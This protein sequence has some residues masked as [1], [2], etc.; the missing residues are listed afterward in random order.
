MLDGLYNILDDIVLENKKRTSIY[1][2]IGSSA[3]TAFYDINMGLWTIDQKNN[4]QYPQFLKTLKE[5]LPFDPLHI[6]LIDPN[7]ENP[8]FITWDMTKN[9]NKHSDEWILDDKYNKYE[10]N[11]YKNIISTI[12]VYTLKS[13]V[14]CY[15]YIDNYLGTN[16]D[17]FFVKLNNYSIEHNWFT[18]VHNFSGINMQI[19]AILYDKQ[20]KHHINHIIYGTAS[21][22]DDGCNFDLTNLNSQYVYEIYENKIHVF[23]PFLN[24]NKKNNEILKISELSQYDEK[25]KINTNIIKE[26]IKE[27]NNFKKNLILNEI[28]TFIRQFGMLLVD[29][30]KVNLNSVYINNLLLSNL[31]YEF[32]LQNL[33]QNKEYDKILNIF[34]KLLHDELV[35]YFCISFGENTEIIITNKI[36]IMLAEK[37]PYRWYDFI[38]QLFL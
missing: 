32:N 22:T 36:N 7:L 8:P 25:S 19:L 17:D 38:K 26:Q 2:S 11:Y 35:S 4:Q 33:Y 27:Y 37:N 1:I 14:K 13:Y 28:M 3:Y 12:N 10:I 30:E 23:N 34:I 20:L 9:N 31:T 5:L 16:I 6:I 24:S 15:P 18:V 21:R 29:P